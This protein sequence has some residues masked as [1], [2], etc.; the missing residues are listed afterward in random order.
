MNRLA[1]PAPFRQRVRR[2]FFPPGP[3][4]RFQELI[5]SR[6]VVILAAAVVGLILGIQWFQ[7]NPRI[8]KTLIGLIVFFVFVRFPVYMGVGAFLLLYP[9]PTAI[10]L[11]NT[12]FVFAILF[13]MV[14]IVK[15]GL[16]LEPRP[17]GSLVGKPIFFLLVAHALSLIVLPEWMDFKETF[18][19][20]QFLLAAVLMYTV[21]TNT[22]TTPKRLHYIFHMLTIGSIIV[23]VQSVLQFIA[24]T[25]RIIPEWY[26]SSP[27]LG[28][29]VEF[30]GRVGGV[31]RSHPL[32][33]DSAAM[34]ILLQL[35]MAS[36]CAGKPWQRLYHFGVIGLAIITLFITV[37]RGG[38]V[39]LVLGLAIIGWHLRRELKFSRIAI[40][41]S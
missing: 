3:P 17:Q 39:I 37:N 36:R 8:V 41:A 4:Q 7:V 18:A 26:Y 19:F 20:Q 1:R 40:A 32:L 38:M 11:G 13:T 23:N 34:M 27:A 28:A 31:F 30:G 35:F 25:L 6:G 15:V 9:Y 12:N 5:I 10:A 21:M 33:A 16:G 24:P 22:V 29:A 2:L 14:W